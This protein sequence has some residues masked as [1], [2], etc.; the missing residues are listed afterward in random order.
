MA[1]TND[2]SLHCAGPLYCQLLLDAASAVSLDVGI[3]VC[4][5]SDNVLFGSLIVAPQYKLQLAYHTI[6]SVATFLV[7]LAQMVAIAICCDMPLLVP[8][9]VDTHR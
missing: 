3:A 5:R 7:A 6:Q 9:Y 2:A 8:Y 4:C 1:Y